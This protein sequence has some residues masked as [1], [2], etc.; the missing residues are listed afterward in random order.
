MSNKIG[1]SEIVLSALFFFIAIFTLCVVLLTYT[2]DNFS[3]LFVLV[4]ATHGVYENFYFIIG[5]VGSISILLTT[6][7]E[8][9]YQRMQKSF[10]YFCYI[11]LFIFVLNAFLGVRPYLIQTD[12]IDSVQLLLFSTPVEHIID[13]FF[14]VFFVAL[15]FVYYLQINENTLYKKFYTFPHNLIPSLNTMMVALFSFAIQPLDKEHWWEWWEISAVLIG[16]MM[17]GYLW[18]RQ[19]ILF[20]SYERFNFIVLIIGVAIFLISHSV[21]EGYASQYAAKKTIYLLAVWGWVLGVIDR[22]KIE[23]KKSLL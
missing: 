13:C 22:H 2:V 8:R 14:F 20:S 21:F 9:S 7:K 10:F 15:P 12:S 11:M 4:S 5:F 1:I 23:Y 6:F 19:K 18:Y 16:L 17:L 3:G